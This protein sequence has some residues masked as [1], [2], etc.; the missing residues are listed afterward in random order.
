MN[1]L[2]AL[3]VVI[4]HIKHLRKILENGIEMDKARS[5]KRVHK[6]RKV[7]HGHNREEDNRQCE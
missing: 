3:E 6:S 4:Q 2:K 7:R 1:D 5:G